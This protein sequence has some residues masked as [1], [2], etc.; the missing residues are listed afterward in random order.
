MNT[1]WKTF[2]TKTAFWLAAEVILNL[3]G[4][5]D[6]ANLSE[7]LTDQQQPDVTVQVVASTVLPNSSQPISLVVA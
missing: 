6:I 1:Q 7:F 4:L 3:A 5:D 2:L